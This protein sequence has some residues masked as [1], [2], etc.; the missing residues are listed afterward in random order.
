M[1]QILTYS[2]S[3]DINLPQSSFEK[4]PNQAHRS[5][6]SLKTKILKKTNFDPFPKSTLMS[7]VNTQ[8]TS[9]APSFDLKNINRNLTPIFKT[10]TSSF[11][12]FIQEP[13]KR[14]KLHMREKKNKSLLEDTEK[15]LNLIGKTLNGSQQKSN[16]VNS[17]SKKGSKSK[18]E[19]NC[20][21]KSYFKN[22]MQLPKNDDIRKKVLIVNKNSLPAIH[23]ST[24]F[25]G[26]L[27]N[28]KNK[29]LKSQG[30]ESANKKLKEKNKLKFSMTIKGWDVDI[31]P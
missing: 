14:S 27:S 6:K 7:Q 11:P 24:S 2:T 18:G 23:K 13:V 3:P 29:E 12:Y 20:V 22:D 28:L 17:F 19:M 16:K 4:S 25:Q 10:S 21:N 1:H 5:N 8:E 30:E 15:N 9:P 31:K 26:L